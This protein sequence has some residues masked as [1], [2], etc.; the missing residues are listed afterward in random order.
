MKVKPYCYLTILFLFISN[1]VQAAYLDINFLSFSDTFQTD[2]TNTISRTM[3]DVGAGVLM[4][5]S[6]SWIW[7]MSYGSGKFTDQ[8][9]TTTTY[10]YTDLGIKMGYFW[11][12]QKSWFST[13]TYN[14][15]SKAKYN[16]GTS[17]VEFRG[18]SI[19]A[20]LGYV[21]WPAE[22]VGVAAKIFYYAPTFTESIASETLTQVS[23]KRAIIY[24]S[25]SIMFSF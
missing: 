4:G 7:A 25:I 3:Y 2:T 11:T 1:G 14:I 9:S 16:D 24:P 6:E 19:K 20:D 18:S 17:E 5:K 23:N 21:F 8:G 22:T 10:S 15:E 13:L 12:K